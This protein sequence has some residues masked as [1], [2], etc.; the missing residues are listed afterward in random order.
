MK[1]NDLKELK[2]KVI[3]K[4][5]SIIYKISKQVCNTLKIIMIGAILLN[6]GSFVSKGTSI[7]YNQNVY[8]EEIKLYNN[9]VDETASLI[10]ELNIEDPTQVF[11]FYI[12][13]LSSGYFS[14]EPFEYNPYEYYDISGSLGIEVISGSGSCRH[15]S[16]L[17]KD[18]YIKAGFEAYTMVNDLDVDTNVITDLLNSQFGNHVITIVYKDDVL[19]G[20]DP[21]NYSTYELKGNDA[22]NLK[23]NKVAKMM[24]YNS[25]KSHI[26]TLDEA[27]KVTKRIINNKSN[28]DYNEYENNYIEGTL[29]HYNN[30]DKVNESHEKIDD[31]IV[32]I[33]EVLKK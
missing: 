9:I 10:N 31:E 3:T 29:M 16:E 7:V 32:K 20:F 28:I 13:L 12:S 24:T 22:Y 15:T 18:V 6:I 11:S 2:E 1:N 25:L 17:L 33:K 19:Y 30:I 27:L 21:T 4:H 8:K 14:N 23:G 5:S 26:I